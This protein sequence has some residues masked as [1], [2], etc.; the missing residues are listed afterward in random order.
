MGIITSAGRMVGER[1]SSSGTRLDAVCSSSPVQ[2]AAG[3][4]SSKS[5]D[6]TV[7]RVG[8]AASAT[9]R[10]SL[11]DIV[12]CRLGVG[13][14]SGGAAGGGGG[15]AGKRFSRDS[16]AAGYVNRAHTASS[17]LDISRKTREARRRD[18]RG[19]LRL[20]R[21]EPNSCTGGSGPGAGGGVTGSS[22]TGTLRVSNRTGANST[23]GG[24][25][26]HSGH[27]VGGYTRNLGC[28]WSFVFDP[29][30]RLCY[31]CGFGSKNWVFAD[32]ES[33]DVVK[34]YLQSYYW[35]TLALTTIGDLP[36]PRSKSEYLFVI[37]Q[38]L[39]GLML[40]ATVLGHV[41]NIVTNVSAARKE[42]QGKY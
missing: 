34:Q 36:K 2:Y 28:R 23:G 5:V 42:F 40:F 33:A 13:A 25:G 38:L 8:G 30:G 17:E 18:I 14:G 6:S 27:G 24:S 9:S 7:S 39:F 1:L 21:W 32:F 22:N 41:A 3:G 4:S 19:R 35:C 11:L 29:A 10:Q 12:S 31:Y 15:G 37:T 26:S 20:E 16:L